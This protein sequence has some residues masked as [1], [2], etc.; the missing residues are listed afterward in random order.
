MLSGHSLTSHQ[1]P[2]SLRFKTG[3]IVCSFFSPK[4]LFHFSVKKYF[5]RSA[6]PNEHGFSSAS[7]SLFFLKRLRFVTF[8]CSF[9]KSFFFFLHVPRQL[10]IR[11]QR[12]T[13]LAAQKSKRRAPPPLPPCYSHSSFSVIKNQTVIHDLG[14]I[15]LCQFKWLC[16]KQLMEHLGGRRLNALIL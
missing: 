4:L 10:C 5:S 16:E 3:T 1:P 9:N 8:C 6:K 11:F 14:S 2:R 7:L 13:F 15:P 12:H